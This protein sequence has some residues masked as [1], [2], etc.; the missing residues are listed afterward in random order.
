MRGADY[1]NPVTVQ[2]TRMAESIDRHRLIDTVGRAAR[3]LPIKSLHVPDAHGAS[4]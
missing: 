2:T 1:V 4:L 3:P